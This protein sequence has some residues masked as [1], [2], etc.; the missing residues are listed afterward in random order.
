MGGIDESGLS[1]V[2]HVVQDVQLNILAEDADLAVVVS[3]ESARHVLHLLV[4]QLGDLVPVLSTHH[5]FQVR[6]ISQLWSVT[7]K[8]YQFT[9]VDRY[10]D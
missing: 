8:L 1:L 10:G 4:H 5:L 9:F 6:E 3:E 7:N 2:Q